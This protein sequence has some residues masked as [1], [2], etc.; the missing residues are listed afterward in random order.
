MRGRRKTCCGFTPRSGFTLVELLAVIAIIGLLIGLLLP[1]IQSS[2]EAARTA[3]CT[4]NL[5]Q[6]GLAFLNFESQNRIFPAGLTAELQGPLATSGKG[7]VHGFMID[8]LPFLEEGGIHSQYDHSAM[9]YSPANANAIAMPLNIALCP[10]SPGD[11]SP[12]SGTFKLSQMASKSVLEKYGLLFSILDNSFSG[13]Y[14]GAPSDY[15]VPVK[16][17]KGLATAYGYTV[18]DTFAELGSMFPLP[19]QAKAIK[20]VTKALISNSVFSIKE[21]TRARQVTDGLSHTYMMSE[22]GGRPEHWERGVRTGTEEPLACAWAN[23]LSM[24]FGLTGNADSTEILNLD[25]NLQV[26]SFHSAGCNFLF[27]DGH[28]DLLTIDTPPRLL[29]ALMTPSRGEVHEPN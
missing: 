26:Y 6:F 28:V 2:R 5:K 19:S 1:A 10:S 24:G 3:Q 7:H 8:L 4:N 17:S 27:A 25:N 11:R 20:S 13:P 15:G 18:E 21:Q 22:I 14:R 16:A 29:V 23:P 9:F 12:V